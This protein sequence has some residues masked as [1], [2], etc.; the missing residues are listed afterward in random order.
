MNSIKWKM[1]LLYILLVLFTLAISGFYIITNVQRNQYR[2]AYKDMEYTAQ[3]IVD[4][5]DVVTLS[6][7]DT[8]ADAFSDVM[9]SMLM[10][11]SDLNNVKIYLLDGRGTPIYHREA[12]LSAADLASRTIVNAIEGIRND[13]LYVH[14][15]VQDDQEVSVGDYALRFRRKQ[16]SDYYILFLRK[17]MS[18]AQESVHNTFLIFIMAALIGILIAGVLGYFLAGTIARP[19]QKLTRKTQVMAE[20]N[21]EVSEEK[22]PEREEKGTAQDEISELDSNFTVMARSLRSILQEMNSETE[23]LETIF[24]NMA[25]G[26]V[27]YDKNGKVQQCNPAAAR[28]MGEGIQREE[29]YRIF[30]PYTQDVKWEVSQI[31]AVNI[32]RGDVYIHAVFAIYSD[33]LIVVL[34]DTTEQKQMEEMQKEFVA[35]VSHELRTP[36][37]TIKSYVETLQDGAS[38]DPAMS[39]RFLNVINNE[40]DRMTHLI[41]ELLDLSR[42]DSRRVKLQMEVL[43]LPLLLH[44][45]V[46]RNRILAEKKNQTMILERITE[47]CFILGDE[48][49]IGQVMRNLLSNA[50]KYSPENTEIR[51]GIQRDP[52]QNVVRVFVKDQGVG[53]E[54]KEQERIFERFYRVD[55]ARSRSMGGTGLGLAISREI[56]D[57]HNGRIWVESHPDEGASSGS[58]FWLEFAEV[59]GADFDEDYI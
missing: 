6:E 15:I 36:I 51:V 40:A 10:E 19:I 55:K 41:A 12:A 32:Q 46:Q 21:L 50:V 2:D 25:D 27:V 30:G 56:M 35:N 49:R 43:D 52:E 57:M 28:L 29:F 31:Q 22:E 9:R 54:A 47:S 53:I 18:E 33:G 26:L 44:E 58:I 1:V 37:T 20:G 45:N 38:A 39:E 48:V 34:Q 7:E 4:T 14:T 42:I 8:L 13:E 23:K 16:D 11:S 3:H 24:A 17:S 5:L 59:E